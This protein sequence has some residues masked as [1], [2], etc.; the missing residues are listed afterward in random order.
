MNSESDQSLNELREFIH[1]LM[2][3]M[4]VTTGQFEM[5]THYIEECKSKLGPQPE[6]AESLTKIESLVQKL[7]VS[8]GAFEQTI[9]E[10]R[11]DVKSRLKT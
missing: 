8:L 11:S 4:T 10:K 9:Q 1:T 7:Q 2:N 5:L 6:L 3:R